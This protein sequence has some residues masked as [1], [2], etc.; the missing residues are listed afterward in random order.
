MLWHLLSYLC[1][2]L[3]ILPT[4]VLYLTYLLPPLWFWNAQILFFFLDRFLSKVVKGYQAMKTSGLKIFF[5]WK[6]S[7]AF[8]LV[9]NT[10]GWI[11]FN[12]LPQWSTCVLVD[13]R[14]LLCKTA[15]S[16]TLPSVSPNRLVL[17]SKIFFLIFLNIWITWLTFKSTLQNKDLKTV[18]ALWI[19]NIMKRHLPNKEKMER[20]SSL[21]K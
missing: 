3:N 16:W 6:I 19:Y 8:Y 4:T 18:P 2:L 20:Y 13:K 17:V 21:E 5:S 15:A 11:V 9:G 7:H 10:Q 12:S 14:P 1:R